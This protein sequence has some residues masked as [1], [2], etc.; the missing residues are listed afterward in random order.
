[1]VATISFL[2]LWAA[3]AGAPEVTR[4]LG[5]VFVTETSTDPAVLRPDLAEVVMRKL[6]SSPIAGSGRCYLHRPGMDTHRYCFTFADLGQGRYRYGVMS[7]ASE[8]S[9]RFLF[10]AYKQELDPGYRDDPAG[11]VAMPRKSQR[12]FWRRTFINM[13]YG[14]AYVYDDNPFTERL[15]FAVVAAYVIEGAHYIPI[16][17]GPFFGKDARA[18]VLIPVIAIASLL[19]WKL[20]FNGV[21]LRSHLTEYNSFADSGYRAPRGVDFGE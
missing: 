2:L 4:F 7:V 17:G 21:L 14:A 9:V 13:G 12:E 3:P 6:G 20:T 11:F 5:T 15:G 16:L 19:F 18:K 1:M 10:S 8:G